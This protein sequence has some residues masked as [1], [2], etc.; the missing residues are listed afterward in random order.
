MNKVSF[1]VLGN[2]IVGGVPADSGQFPW[3]VGVYYIATAGGLFF[4][5]GTLISPQYV[6]T[7]GHCATE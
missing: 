1:Y 5:G 7:A 3:Q 6:I 2:R 4:C